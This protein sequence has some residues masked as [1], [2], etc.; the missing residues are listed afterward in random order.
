VQEKRIFFILSACL[1][2]LSMLPGAL[3]GEGLLFVHHG[4]VFGK[5]EQAVTNAVGIEI[6]WGALNRGREE[7][8]TI[9]L[10]DGQKVNATRR[11]LDI[12]SADS[13]VWSGD[14][15][16]QS[17]G[18]VT[19]SIV[20]SVLAGGIIIDGYE[21]YRITN[22]GPGPIL[23]QIDHNEL[24]EIEAEDMV[25]PPHLA[26]QPTDEA[27]YCEDGSQIDLQVA[28][29]RRARLQVGGT[30]AMR[31]L[32]NQRISD[33][34][35]A[36][37]GSGLPF[38]YHLAHTLETR[39]P[40]TGDVAQDL[41]H[42]RHVGDGVFDDVTAA[43]DQH[44]ADLTSLVIAE[45][46]LGS[47]CGM[48]FVMNDLS[49]S[50]A[51]YAY[52]IVALDYAGNNL[53][54]NTLTMA[55]EFGHNMGNQ[56]NRNANS[57][58]PLLPYAFGYQSPSQSFRTIMAYNCPGGCP[59][60]NYWSNPDITYGGEAVGVSHERSQLRSAN[61]SRSMAATALHVANFR[62]NCESSVAPPPSE[63]TPPG[64][65]PTA[66]PPASSSPFSHRSYVP[67]L[68]KN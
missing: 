58:P 7:E 21:R 68:F 41:Q 29:T 22:D 61:N 2:F 19:L 27:T 6:N 37:I 30:A 43:R 28:Y 15:V 32:I 17:S 55:H 66:T 25:F 38:R 50:F 57:F 48:A 45:A 51:D 59:R 63:P 8:I 23:R 60:I 65:A 12:L 47:G 46:Q 16:G 3:A 33:M 11:R 39:D 13:Y 42:L 1:A 44:K 52:N 10:F 24:V 14:I 5:Q 35:S 49:T 67:A 9:N 54:C 34:N 31:A 36:N 64:A 18:T 40:S 56:H 4:Q 62:E 20:E 26:N 53:A